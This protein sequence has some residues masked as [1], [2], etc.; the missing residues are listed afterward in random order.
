MAAKRHKIKKYVAATLAI[1]AGF[2]YLHNTSLLADPIGSQPV[3]LAHRG[4][5]QGY[6]K[7]GLNNETCTAAQMIR[8]DHDYLE[9]TIA[10]M[11][12]ALTQQY[13]LP[14]QKLPP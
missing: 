9:N 14:E 6:S 1:F 11:E 13:S 5:A 7:E 8:S 12:A 2:V 4:L 3:L 10:S